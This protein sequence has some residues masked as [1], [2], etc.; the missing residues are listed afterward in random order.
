M[1]LSRYTTDRLNAL[2]H[3]DKREKYI[4]KM[5]IV[6]EPVDMGLLPDARTM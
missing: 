2:C 1:Y 3:N 6:E 5:S 4:P